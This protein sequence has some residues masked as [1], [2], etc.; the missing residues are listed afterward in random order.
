MIEIANGTTTR[1]II[2]GDLTDAQLLDSD[3]NNNDD[4]VKKV[5]LR[6]VKLTVSNNATVTVLGPRDGLV[7]T[8]IDDNNDSVA[9]SSGNVD[10]TVKKNDGT[11]LQAPTAAI[12]PHD[13]TAWRECCPYKKFYQR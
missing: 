4:D 8:K 11:N 6:D 5:T 13:D 2:V 3:N 1:N 9:A 7:N 12:A 10:T